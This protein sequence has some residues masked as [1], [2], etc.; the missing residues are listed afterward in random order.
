MCNCVS[1]PAPPPA[2]DGV[3]YLLL[4]DRNVITT[5]A[6]LVLGE[7]RKNPVGALIKEERDY[8]MRFDNMQ[9]NVWFDPWLK[10]W[11]AWYSAFTSCSAPKTA[12]PYCNNAPQQCGSVTDTAKNHA[13]R[14]SGLLY[15]ESDDGI[16]WTKPNL[17]KTMWKG[18]TANNL[19]ELDGMTTGIY[20]DYETTN[21]SE[22]YKIVTGSNGN[23]GICIS[24]D[25]INWGPVKNLEGDTH[26]RWDTP[27]NLAWDPDRE[28]WIIYLRAQP[29]ENSLRVQ[30][31][32]HSLS[33]HFMGDWSP[34][35]PTGLNSSADYQPDG[36]VV[37]PY[38]GIY[39]G[40][41]NIFNPTQNVAVE[42][43]A[44][45]QVNG[46]LG[47]SADGR[48]W[49]W[50]RPHDSFIPLGNAGDFDSCGVFGAKQDPLRT[51]VNGTLR[52]YYA[53]CN[54]PFFGSRGCALGVAEIQQDG[55]AGYQGGTLS[56]APF[57]VSTTSL[58]VSVDGGTTGI[59][60]GIAGHPTYTIENCDPIVGKQT[61]YLVTW[62]GQSDIKELNGAFSLEFDIPKDATA[63][64]VTV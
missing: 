42:G 14:G 29:T 64:A 39:L 41:G 32:S 4:D 57:R 25:G 11:R 46:V 50:I 36:L 7:V 45:G 2:P 5:T 58:K 8:E 62:K 33:P 3:K 15:A 17:N 10:K 63:F 12:V 31:Y 22:R 40:I 38:A 16:T 51:V 19:L 49:K 52:V 56:T 23:G 9:P 30:S 6:T 43:A 35:T 18:S 54:G 34:A 21:S 24:S 44:I 47:W 20:L 1:A 60:V 27:K 61:D 13:G 37:W 53:G 28:Q 55:W 26:A 48:R 59:R